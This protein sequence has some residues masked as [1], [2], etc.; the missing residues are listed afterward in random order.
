MSDLLSRTILFGLGCAAAATV[1]CAGEQEWVPGDEDNIRYVVASISDARNSSEKLAELFTDEAVPNKAWLQATE[2]RSFVVGE[3]EVNGGV[4]T[5]P[6]ELED[7]MGEV[8]G[9][10]TWQCEKVDGAWRISAAPLP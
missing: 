10:S 2:R 1:G 3:I 5:F 4:A 8:K 6:V 9:T 7:Y